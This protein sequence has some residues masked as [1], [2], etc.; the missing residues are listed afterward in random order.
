MKDKCPHCHKIIETAGF[1]EKK[2]PKC[3]GGVFITPDEHDKGFIHIVVDLAIAGFPLRGDV[4][5][6][7]ENALEML[8]PLGKCAS[9]VALEK[10]NT[11]TQASLTLGL[12]CCID[13]KKEVEFFIW[14][15]FMF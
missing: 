10:I 13:S 1:G 15:P 11:K 7:T 4:F 8:S 6:N 14:M 12:F 3:G 2:C 5:I 9:I